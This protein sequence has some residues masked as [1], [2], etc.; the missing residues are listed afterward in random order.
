MSVYRENQFL[1]WKMPMNEETNYDQTCLYKLFQVAIKNA[2]FIS[3]LSHL[4]NNKANTH[5]SR[6]RLAD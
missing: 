3:K 5:K 1:T 4:I 6:A 2:F